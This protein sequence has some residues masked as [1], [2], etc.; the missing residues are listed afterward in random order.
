MS[1]L[2][3]TEQTL[4]LNLVE[5]GQRL[6]KRGFIAGTDGNLSVRLGSEW[7]LTTPSGVHKGM[8]SPEQIVKCDLEG[9]PAGELE[10]SSEIRMH[11]LVYRARPD[12]AAAVHAHPVNSVALSLV[13]VNLAECLLPEAALALGS[14]PTAPYA[15][16]TTDDVPDSIQELLCQRFN[17]LILARHGTLTLGRTLEEAFIR[18]ETVEHTARITAVARSIG[19]TYALPPAEVARIETIARA[20]GIARPSPGCSG[21]GTCGLPIGEGGGA[22]GDK[23][24]MKGSAEPYVPLVQQSIMRRT[25]EL[26]PEELERIQL[27]AQ[28][29]CSEMVSGDDGSAQQLIGELTEAVLRRLGHDRV[30]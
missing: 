13:G 22:V 10:P 11:V 2:I 24:S 14:I 7:M 17:A 27:V 19:P 1:A 18:L 23:E 30:R 25:P 15:T 8:L 29:L 16:P 5:V 21:C 9:N 20:F 4:R 6:Y 26:P 12:V 3:D 28:G